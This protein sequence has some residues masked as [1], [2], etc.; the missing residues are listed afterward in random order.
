MAPGI[1]PSMVASIAPW[2]FAKANRCASVVADAPEHQS[3]NPVDE[4]R[5][6]GRK[7]WQAPSDPNIEASVATASPTAT[8][9]CARCT[10][11]LTNPSSG[12]AEVRSIVARL[13][14]ID[15][16]QDAARR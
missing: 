3:G 12:I 5:S 9:P 4:E 15:A 11:T 14:F 8:L 1:P 2:A 7:S 13:R 16:I 10:E 6:S